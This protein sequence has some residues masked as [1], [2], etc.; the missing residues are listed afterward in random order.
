MTIYRYKLYKLC[1]WRHNMPPPPASL[2]IISCKYENRQRLQFTIEFAKTNNNNNN[3]KKKHC[4]ILASS[5]RHSQSKAKH[6][7]IWA[8]AR[9]ILP[10]KQF[11][12]WPSDL[13]S[14]VR[15]TC[16][17]GYLCANFSVPRPLCSRVRPDVRSRRQTKASLNAST[18]WG[19]EA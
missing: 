6:N 4:A 10:I 1:A 16:D 14:G 18:Q 9:P 2:T 12:L 15:V 11:D 13:E 5:C 7:R 17:V 19:A 3:I 8:Q